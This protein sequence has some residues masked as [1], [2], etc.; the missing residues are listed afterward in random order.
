MC[1]QIENSPERSN[2]VPDSNHE[3]AIDDMAVQ[4]QVEA[5]SP[6]HQ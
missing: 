5:P 1:K 6:L 3:A 4:L 2:V